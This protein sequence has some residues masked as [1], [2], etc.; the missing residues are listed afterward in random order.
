MAGT[1]PIDTHGHDKDDLDALYPDT[2]SGETPASQM[3][4]AA[5]DRVEAPIVPAQTT[6]EVEAQ[7]G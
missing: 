2:P 6:Q 7:L 1:D 5:G 3:D 4:W